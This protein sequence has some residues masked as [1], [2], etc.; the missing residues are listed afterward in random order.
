[1][2]RL[3]LC[4]RANLGETMRRTVRSPLLV[5]ALA[6]SLAG[7]AGGVEEPA[8]YDQPFTSDVATLLSFEFDGQLTA[9]S[10][11]TKG[12]IR[13]QLLYTVGH[14][15]GESGVARLER[16]TTSNVTTTSLGGGLYRIKY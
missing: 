16:L 8:E 3:L 1:M 9:A 15:N 7:C 2:V 5:S 14:L 6:L 13:A 12:L 11:N 10:T 4:A